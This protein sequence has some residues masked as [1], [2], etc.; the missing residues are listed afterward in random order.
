VLDLLSFSTT[1]FSEMKLVVFDV[2]KE[3]NI[4]DDNELIDDNDDVDVVVVD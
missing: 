1:D 2:V 3:D 4:D